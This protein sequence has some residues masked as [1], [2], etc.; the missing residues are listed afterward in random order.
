[1]DLGLA[2]LPGAGLLRGVGEVQQRRLRP[3]PADELQAHGEPSPVVP[4]RHGDRRQSQEVARDRVPHQRSSIDVVELPGG[5]RFL[6]QRVR[7][8]PATQAQRISNQV[9]KLSKQR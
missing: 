7:R 2:V 1:M 3:W 4:H 6:L 8:H 5:Q 9:T